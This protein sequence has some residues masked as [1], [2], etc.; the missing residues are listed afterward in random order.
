[1]KRIGNGPELMVG[2]GLQFSLRR[3]HS[4]AC[5]CQTHGHGLAPHEA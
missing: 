1:M 4:F 3:C 2:L 5:E